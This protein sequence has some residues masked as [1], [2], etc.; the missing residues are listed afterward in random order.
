M[1]LL[2]WSEKR[3]VEKYSQLH[4][5][6]NNSNDLFLEI[7]Q[8][9]RQKENLLGCFL[10]HVNGFLSERKTMVKFSESN[11][12]AKVVYFAQI[13]HSLSLKRTNYQNFELIRFKNK[14]K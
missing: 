13:F 5:C 8:E 2:V 12:A 11:F 1:S 9:I 10:F 6:R 14:F 4:A 7:N 3:E